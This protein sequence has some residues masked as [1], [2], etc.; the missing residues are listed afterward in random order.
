MEVSEDVCDSDDKTNE[1]PSTRL[2][3]KEDG[4]DDEMTSIYMFR[5]VT[6]QIPQFLKYH[7]KKS[8]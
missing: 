2:S 3:D 1:P 5:I 7:Q 6:K 8:Q 4:D